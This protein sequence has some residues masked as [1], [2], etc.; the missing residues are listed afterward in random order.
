MSICPGQYC[1]IVC[2]QSAF[3]APWQFRTEVCCSVCEERLKDAYDQLVQLVLW[4]KRKRVCPVD[5]VQRCACGRARE[6]LAIV[7]GR[8]RRLEW[9]SIPCRV[10]VAEER[11]LSK[12]MF[13]VKHNRALINKL[14]EAIRVRAN[15]TEHDREAEGIP[16][17]RAC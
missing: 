14:K 7:W 17:N 16:G 2:R 4:V 11:R 5:P 9:S 10:C 6:M 13:N 12:Q 15:Q 1:C 8:A 3:Y